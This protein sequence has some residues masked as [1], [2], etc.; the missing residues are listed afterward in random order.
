MAARALFGVDGVAAAGA[1]YRMAHA[2]T[3][4]PAA[5]L[6][7]RSGALGGPVA[8]VP[9]STPN[10]TVTVPACAF[11]VDATGFGGGSMT[12]VNDGPATLT[13]PAASATN[14]RR[15][16]VVA[17]WADESTGTV[18]QRK[19]YFEVIPGTP[20]TTP[21]F[22]SIPGNAH[23]IA[24]ISVGAGQTSIG[25]SHIVNRL[26]QTVAL[27][28]IAPSRTATDVAA[29]YPGQYRTRL[30]SGE[31][32]VVS[33]TG[34]RLAVQDVLGAATVSGPGAPSPA[35]TRYY[36]QK[37]QALV[38]INQYGEAQVSFPVAFP[39]RCIGLTPPS[40]IDYPTIAAGAPG[41]G[42]GLT[43]GAVTGRW[44]GLSTTGAVVMLFNANGTKATGLNQI[45]AVATG[46]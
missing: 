4:Y 45:F 12:V 23:I 26:F 27:G 10:M 34:W 1:D 9:Q 32:E 6:Q 33:G 17:R 30:D 5:V 36:D 16:Y 41:A 28:G 7:A 22:P 38:S 25:A 29:V 24:E 21:Q 18:S 15:D 20:A 2:A 39:T 11:E 8:V 35:T 42:N 43:T 40:V 19:A 46:Y 44:R 31:L 37:V 3:M 14:P 13:V